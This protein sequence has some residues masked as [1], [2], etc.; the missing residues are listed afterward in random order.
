M[1]VPNSWCKCAIKLRDVSHRKTMPLAA[2]KNQFIVVLILKLINVKN[3]SFLS[4]NFSNLLLQK[5]NYLKL[6]EDS[7]SAETR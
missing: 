2:G 7:G 5:F 1:S 4:F 6:G 3:C